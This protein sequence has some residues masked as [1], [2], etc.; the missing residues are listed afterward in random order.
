M[1]IS[2][3]HIICLGFL[4]GFSGPAEAQTNSSTAQNE[5]MAGLA[6]EYSPDLKADYNQAA[7]HYETA[8]SA[9]SREAALALTRLYRPEGPLWRNPETW[10]EKLL[11]ACRA[12]WPEAAFDLAEALEKGLIDDKTLNP[13]NYYLQA[14]SAGHSTAAYKLSLIYQNGR[15][16]LPPN[17]AQSL[18]WLTIAAE[19][20]SLE[21]ALEL[22]RILYK[23]NPGAAV[24]WLEKADSP[25]AY[26]LLGNLY[27]K[28]K[29]FIEAVNS[30]TTSADLGYAP[31]HLALGLINMDNEF[32]RRTNPREALKHFKIAAQAD[33]PEG[34]YQLAHM[35]LKGTAT[36]KDPITGAYWLNRAA[37]KG[38]AAAKEEFDKSTYNFSVGQI[39]RLERMIEDDAAPHSLTPAQ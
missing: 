15:H 5:F 4:I 8:A 28:D 30:Y 11:I 36:P 19:N 26:Y 39:K 21:A 29:R 9:G 33:L 10:R 1:K 18:M 6:K 34:A 13:A 17:E 20:H 2:A 38:H 27:L 7:A 32:G 31:A 14:A 25:E 37:T 24:R 22:G 16:G 35:Y 3:L 12:G 23:N